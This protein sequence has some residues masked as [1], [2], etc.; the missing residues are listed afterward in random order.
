MIDYPAAVDDY[1]RT[2]RAMGYKLAQDGRLLH[3]FAAYL[4]TVGAEH[5]TIADAL[6]WATEPSGAAAAWRAGRLGIVRSFARYLIALDPATEIP[7]A[8]LLAEPSHRVVPHIYT[9]EDLAA[10]LQEAGRLAPEHRADTYQT[11]IGLIAVTGMRVGEIVRL[12]RDDIDHDEGIVTVR[13]TKYGKSRQLPVL[14]DLLGEHG[15]DTVIGDGGWWGCRRRCWRCRW[16][17]SGCRGC[18]D[19]EGA[20]VGS[21]AVVFEVAE[22]V[23]EG[24]GGEGVGAGL[25]GE[26][27]GD[28]DALA[29]GSHSVVTSVTAARAALSSMMEALLA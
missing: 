3:H 21:D 26:V 9:D 29:G 22:D 27:E 23:E 11:L 5:L 24:A 8:G 2:R 6:S 17:C 25:V 4:Q 14:P 10:V 28:D 7:P 1:L 15:G 19:L 16:W 13:N 12:D 18:G 20:A